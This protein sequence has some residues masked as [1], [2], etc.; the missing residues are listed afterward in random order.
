MKGKVICPSCQQAR[1]TPLK[2][3]LLLRRYSFLNQKFFKICPSCGAKFQLC[4]CGKVLNLIHLALDPFGMKVE[5]PACGKN[6]P[7][8]TEWIQQLKT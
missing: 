6:Y 3:S 1:L 8:I 4:T 7:K 2:D 5:C